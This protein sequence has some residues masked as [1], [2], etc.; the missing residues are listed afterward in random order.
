MT[1]RTA[2]QGLNRGAQASPEGLGRIRRHGRGPGLLVAVLV[3]VILALGATTGAGADPNPTIPSSPGTSQAD[4]TTCAGIGTEDRA[5]G[6]E[7]TASADRASVTD[8]GTSTAPAWDTPF[9]NTVESLTEGLGQALTMSMAWWAKLPNP[10]LGD[11]S[12]LLGQVGDYTVEVQLYFLVA[13][14]I[15]C[16]V[17]LAQ[18]RHRAVLHEATESFRVLARTVFASTTWAGVLVLATRAADAYSTWIINDS[19]HGHA[20][21]VAAQMISPDQLHA[22]SPGLVLIVAVAGLTGALAQMVVAVLRQVMLIAAAGFLPLAAAASGTRA[23]RGGYDKLLAWSIAFLL[24]KPIAATVYMIA[25]VTAGA[26]GAAGSPTQAGQH[27]LIGIALLCS[28]A[29]V[30]P[31]LLHLVSPLARLAGASASAS[32]SGGHAVIGATLATGSRDTV[33]GAV[34]R[35]GSAANPPTG[36]VSIAA[37]KTAGPI[38]VGGLAKTPAATHPGARGAARA[39]STTA[40]HAGVDRTGGGRGQRTRFGRGGSAVAR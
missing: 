35:V 13:S 31:A 17:R 24:W 15:I 30:L 14:V 39:A 1:T 12:G 18:A 25:F 26:S 34:R 37:T 38:G 9:G 8:H 20:K 6:A 22:F 32:A 11:A 28:A 4:P 23:G 33:I 36:T 3:A 2:G 29:L 27:T 10:R 16:G 21:T 5:G 40:L 7:G 19:T